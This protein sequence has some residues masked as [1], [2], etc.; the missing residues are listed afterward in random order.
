M[1]VP[2]CML[3]LLDLDTHMQFKPAVPYE[4]NRPTLLWKSNGQ[5]KSGTPSPHWKHHFVQFQT[6]IPHV[7][8]FHV[9]ITQASKL[10]RR[11]AIQLVDFDGVHVSKRTMNT[12]SL[13]VGK[14]SYTHYSLAYH[15]VW[16]PKYRRR[17]LTGEV[18]K[19]TKRLMRECCSQHGLTL[20]A[21]ETNEDHIHVFVSAPPRFSPALIANHLKGY[22]SRFLRDKFLTSRN[23]GERSF[24]GPRRTMSARLVTFQWRRSGATLSSVKE[25]RSGAFIPSPKRETGLPAV[26]IKN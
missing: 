18:Q 17:I 10:G 12:A 22:F 4:G 11:Q 25:N 23:S 5:N 9:S 13:Q 16:T 21:M 14:T 15:F 3:L 26:P 6:A 2:R 1:Y 24:F 19:E 7:C 20:R 8:R